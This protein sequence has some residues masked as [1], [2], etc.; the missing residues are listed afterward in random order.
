MTQEELSRQIGKSRSAVAN[1]MRLLDLPDESKPL[2]IALTDAL[3]VKTDKGIYRRV[4]TDE[5]VS[6]DGPH[7]RSGDYYS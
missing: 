6:K 2:A 1:T 5:C 4:L 7:W 3:Y